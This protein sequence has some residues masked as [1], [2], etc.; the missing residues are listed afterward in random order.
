VKEVKKK[1]KTNTKTKTKAKTKPIPIPKRN[2]RG[3][4]DFLMHA[5]LAVLTLRPQPRNENK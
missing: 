4:N 1:A 3:A 5:A 2:I